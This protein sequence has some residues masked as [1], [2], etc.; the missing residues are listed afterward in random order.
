METMVEDG[1]RPAYIYCRYSSEMQSQGDSLRRQF[2]SCNDAIKK[3]N[4]YIKEKITD[5]AFSGYHGDNLLNGKLKKFIDDANSGDIEPGAILIVE[6]LDR[7]TRLQPSKALNIIMNILNTGL[8]IY[9]TSPSH[10]FSFKDKTS[11]AINIIMITLFAQRA[12]EE[13]DTKSYRVKEAWMARIE[14]ILKGEQKI[15]LDKAPYWLDIVEKKFETTDEYGNISF[16]KMKAYE[17]NKERS[18]EVLKILELLKD[19]GFKDACK[20]INQESKKVWTVKALQRLL[21]STTLYGEWN[22]NLSER[23]DGK[24]VLKSRGLELPAIYPAIIS[25]HDFLTIKERIQFRSGG[26]GGGRKST[27]NHNIFSKL[28]FCAHCGGTMRFMHKKVNGKEGEAHYNYLVCHNSEIGMCKHNKVL[29]LKY[30][31][32][33]HAFFKYARYY[34]LD[35]IFGGKKK[36]NYGFEIS[37]IEKEITEK[38]EKFSNIFGNMFEKFNG[39]IPEIYL[40]ELNKIEE[41][42]KESTSKLEKLNHQEA[43]QKRHSHKNE[44]YEMI[45]GV[46]SILTVP[47]NRLKMNNHLK[48]IIKSI[49]V[50]SNKV[51]GEGHNYLLIEF[52]RVNLNHFIFF[53]GFNVT[54]SSNDKVDRIFN[55]DFQEMFEDLD[56]LQAYDI[57]SLESKGEVFIEDIKDLDNP[58][59]KNY[60]QD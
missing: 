12:H 58:K 10:L 6:N 23:E 17:I 29:T 36:I 41:S 25:K 22:L 37:F 7:I 15:V 52:E 8:E 14:R 40:K 26:R 42:I 38:K 3:Y 51:S 18:A 9:Q 45:H 48:T 24:K 39:D 56:L 44:I 28:I 34:D 5:E 43:L 2:Q 32:V 16:K 35:S 46:D 54:H 53:N 59:W 49:T 1:K 47:E 11:E 31:E 55:F 13:S 4:L 57:D 20:I 30:E 21:E 33:E 50:S 19:I 60:S 27:K